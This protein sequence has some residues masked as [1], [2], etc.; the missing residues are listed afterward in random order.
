[1][2]VLSIHLTMPLISI[3]LPPSLPQSLKWNFQQ[4][5]QEHIDQLK[6]QLLACTSRSLHT[7]LF[8][9]NFKQHLAAIA[10]LTKVVKM[11]AHKDAV[12]GCLDSLLRWVTLRFFDTNTTVNLKCLELLHVLFGGLVES[13]YRMS[14]YEASSFLPYLVQKVR[15][16]HHCLDS[17]FV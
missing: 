8:H 3:S 5:R 4:P 17:Y 16:P 14:D 11:D 6:D 15:L 12:I 1:M 7:Q 9:E 2:Y 10:S 13:G